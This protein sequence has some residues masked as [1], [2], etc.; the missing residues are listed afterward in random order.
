MGM[1][2]GNSTVLK[3]DQSRSLVYS[4]TPG[5]EPNRRGNTHD[6]TKFSEFLKIEGPLRTLASITA[7]SSTTSPALSVLRSPKKRNNYPFFR[8]YVV[9][10]AINIGLII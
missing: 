5:H 10:Q 2:D 6:A 4:I 7:A 9:I 1:I 8:G 3:R